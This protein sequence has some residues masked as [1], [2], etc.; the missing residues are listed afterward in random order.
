LTNI[1]RDIREDWERDRLYLPADELASH[2]LSE[3]DFANQRHDETFRAMMRAQILRAREFYRAAEQG[4]LALPN[5]GSRYCARLMSTV[6]GAILDEIE[7][8]D[9][10]VFDGRVRVALPRKL[11]LAAGAWLEIGLI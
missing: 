4:I 1:L 8:V 7:R 11:W 3:E 10:R 2:G 9:Y 5:D 6:Y